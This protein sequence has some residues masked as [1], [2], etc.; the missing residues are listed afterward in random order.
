MRQRQAQGHVV[1]TFPGDE[2]D[3]LPDSGGSRVTME[4]QAG[5]TQDFSIKNGDTTGA[6]T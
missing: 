2:V 5:R 6:G 1:L 3:E 4:P